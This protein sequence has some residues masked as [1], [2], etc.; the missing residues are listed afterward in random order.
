MDIYEYQR[1]QALLLA[2]LL[3]TVVLT[4]TLS[5]LSRS[6]VNIRLSSEEDQSQI[7]LSAAEAGIERSLNASNPINNGTLSN[8]STFTTTVSNISGNEILVNNGKVI[9][10]DMGAD[11][12]LSDYSTDKNLIYKNDW[13]GDLTVYWG[14]PSD[15]CQAAES[16]NTMAALELVFLYGNKI[17]P[18]VVRYAYDPCPARRAVNKLSIPETGGTVAGKAFA[19]HVNFNISNPYLL[20]RAIPLYTNTYM[21]VSGYPA[22]PAQ[23]TIINSTG[24]TGDVKRSISVT[25]ENPMLPAEFFN[26]TFL[27]VK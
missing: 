22:L 26:Y 7:A 8:N 18:A 20:L 25:R 23:A 14:S 9:V 11:I 16:I 15:S 24:S 3:V 6:I 13:A 19:N 21:G 10:K 1:G 27:W 12:W 17:N 2:V 5:L 4:V